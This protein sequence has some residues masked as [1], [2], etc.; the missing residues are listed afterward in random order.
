[1]S[2]DVPLLGKISS[3]QQQYEDLKKDGF[4]DEEAKTLVGVNSYL[5]VAPGL[6]RV[7]ETKP[8][9]A[10]EQKIMTA[11]IPKSQT[12]EGV[13]E[14]IKSGKPA[15]GTVIGDR[16][17]ITDVIKVIGMYVGQGIVLP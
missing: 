5:S 12:R 15:E 16:P 7:R 17:I 6:K 8:V 10:V 2:A 14:Q 4:S 9:Q 11:E 13:I 3:W 1:M